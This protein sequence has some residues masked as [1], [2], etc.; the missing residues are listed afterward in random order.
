[1]FDGIPLDEEDRKDI[2]EVLKIASKAIQ[3][4]KK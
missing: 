3:K 4:R 2:M 1:M